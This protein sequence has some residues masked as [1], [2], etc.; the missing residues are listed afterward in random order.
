MTLVEGIQIASG[1]THNYRIAINGNREFEGVLRVKEEK[2][3]LVTFAQTILA[4][5]AVS[6][7]TLTNVG[8]SVAVENEGLISDIDDMGSTYYFRGN[9]TNN[10]VSFANQTWRVVRING[11]GSVK[12]ILNGVTDTVQAFYSSNEYEEFY[13][14]EFSSIKEYLENWY[15]FNLQEYDEYIAIDKYCNDYNKTDNLFN[16]YI[17]NI[18][19]KIP[20]FNCLG[21]N[22]GTKIGLI[23]AD[24]VIYAG[25]LY[26]EN[27]TSYYLYNPNIATSWWTMTPA[28]GTE[29]SMNPFL[30]NESGMIVDDVLGTLNRSIRPVINLSKDVAVTG[31]GTVANPYIINETK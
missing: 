18:T 12:L 1:E 19:N 8:E 26:K 16:S 21:E 9:V 29:T 14:Y 20:T 10:Y 2:P 23:T 22:I 13:Q 11:D 31:D 17:R 25:G 30:V 3:K 28:S 24:E 7:M 27:N 6:D 4:N 5:N 15:E